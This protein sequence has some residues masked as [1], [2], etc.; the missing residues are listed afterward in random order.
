MTNTIFITCA[1]MAGGCAL[2]FIIQLA[3]I[4]GLYNRVCRKQRKEDTSDANAPSLPPLSVIIV[5]KDSGEAL[6]R[7]LPQILE[8]DYPKF[9]VIVVNDK[10][11]GEDEDIL[12]RLSEKYPN[13]YHTFIPG[14][15]RYVSRK[16]LG[17]A[18]GIRASKYEWV[19][20]T[21]P[22]CHPTSKNWL[23]SLAREMT[24]DTDKIG[25]AHV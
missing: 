2:L 9:E 5:T 6:N 24:P 4:F 1:A 16:K 11:A 14:T 20:T 22:Y 7:N 8:Q 3:Y 15:A 12:K 21:E 13:L 25:R 18:M 17:M 10:S 23:R 19:V